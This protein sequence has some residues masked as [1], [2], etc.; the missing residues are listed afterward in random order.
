MGNRRIKIKQ[1]ELQIYLNI[2]VVF[3]NKIF[4]KCHLQPLKYPL[5]ENLIVPQKKGT[6]IRFVNKKQIRDLNNQLKYA[7]LSPKH[8]KTYFK[9]NIINFHVKKFF[10]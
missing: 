3:V 2:A 6:K 4:V 1:A 5:V 7:T 9:L 8:M 10:Y